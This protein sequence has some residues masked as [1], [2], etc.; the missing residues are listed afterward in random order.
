MGVWNRVFALGGIVIALAAIIILWS[1]AITTASEGLV[2]G[3]EPSLESPTVVNS[4]DRR[5][6]DLPG[7]AAQAEALSDQVFSGL[8][9]TQ[10]LIGKT[11]ARNQAIEQGRTRARGKLQDLA[12]RA[13]QAHEQSD[14]TGLS[15]TDRRVLKHI[16]E[17]VSTDEF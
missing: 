11:E 14:K 12:E 2:P 9:T 6:L 5:E 7:A 15:E 17:S 1:T 8:E 16:S 13:R 4:D 10:K 3:R